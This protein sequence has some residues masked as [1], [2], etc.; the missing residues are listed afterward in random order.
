M[1]RAEEDLIRKIGTPGGMF[2]G[3][4]QA[5]LDEAQGRLRQAR[6]AAQQAVGARAAAEL[7]VR[8]L[9]GRSRAV[10]STCWRLTTW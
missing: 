10:R 1:I 2:A 8:L 5:K 9:S 7:Q 3:R 4:K 6:V